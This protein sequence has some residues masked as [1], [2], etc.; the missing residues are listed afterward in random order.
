MILLPSHYFSHFLVLPLSISTFCSMHS[1]KWK[2]RPYVRGQQI[3]LHSWCSSWGTEEPLPRLHPLHLRPGHA[4][5]WQVLERWTTYSLP[6]GCVYHDGIGSVMK[7]LVLCIV[8][9][10]L[11]QW[12]SEQLVQNT[13]ANVTCFILTMF[14]KSSPSSSHSPVKVIT[15]SCVYFIFLLVSGTHCVFYDCLKAVGQSS[16]V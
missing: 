15:F 14:I 1:K 7:L 2:T 6:P 10:L 5:N 8:L 13:M 12:L 16:T 4:D 9:L 3:V 11:V